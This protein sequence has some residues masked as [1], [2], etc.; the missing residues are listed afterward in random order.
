MKYEYLNRLINEEDEELR[1]VEVE[2]FISRKG[3]SA[4]V[5][6]YA[7]QFQVPGKDLSPLRKMLQRYVDSM[8]NAEAADFIETNHKKSQRSEVKV[9][10][11]VPKII[12]VEVQREQAKQ[13]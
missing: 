13:G 1:A 12:L 3:S 7:G 11:R 6:G 2:I 4:S 10:V 8:T 9:I 5:P